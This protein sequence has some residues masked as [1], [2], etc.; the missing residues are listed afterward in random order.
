MKNVTVSSQQQGSNPG[1]PLVG[2]HK[3]GADGLSWKTKPCNQH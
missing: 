2:L 3:A 1:I